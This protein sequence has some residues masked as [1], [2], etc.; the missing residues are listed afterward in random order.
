MPPPAFAARAYATIGLETGIAAASPHALILML[1]DA[2]LKS[3]ADA[4]GHLGA[5]RIAEKGRAVSRAITIIEEGLVASLDERQGGEIAAQ[6]RQLYEY[7]TPRLLVASLR[8]DPAGFDEVAGLLADLRSAWVDVP[9]R[10]AAT[11]PSRAGS[12]ALA[13]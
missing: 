4:R 13:R 3:I 2:A 6:L 10:A 5:Q 12:V 9:R 7:M 8:K 11:A 1:Y